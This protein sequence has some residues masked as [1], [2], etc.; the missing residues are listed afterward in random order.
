MFI[1]TKRE[2]FS[3]QVA[4]LLREFGYIR[5]LQEHE[6]GFWCSFSDITNEASITKIIAQIRKKH[7][8]V[9]S[10]VKSHKDVS[11]YYLTN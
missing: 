10:S 6:T 9:F 8:K 1:E 11:T 7:G 2:L 3:V 4:E 5:V